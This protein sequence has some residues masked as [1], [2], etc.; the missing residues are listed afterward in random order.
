[1]SVATKRTETSQNDVGIHG[2]GKIRFKSMATCRK[3]ICKDREH[4]KKRQEVV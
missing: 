4:L 1:M 2:R 3:Q